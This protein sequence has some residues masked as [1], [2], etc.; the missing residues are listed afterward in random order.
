MSEADF[1]AQ[2]A[3]DAQVAMAQA[4]EELKHSLTTGVDVKQWTARYPWIATG[5]A[6]AAGVAAGYLL[7]PRDR[8]EAA[9]MWEKLKAKL[10]GSGQA[11]EN[12]VY[13][14]AANGKPAQAPQQSSSLLG[15]IAKEAMKSLMPM[16]TSMLGGAI[17]GGQ[18]QQPDDAGQHST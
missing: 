15:T 14:E 4:W 18:A 17:G 6:L 2:Q 1:L 7:T 11:D 10:S 3:A 9:E 16:L 8:D 13:V 5:T 12:T